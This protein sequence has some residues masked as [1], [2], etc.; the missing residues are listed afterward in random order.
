MVELDRVLSCYEATMKD[1]H[2][3]IAGGTG[4]L[5]TEITN[6]V[7]K[8]GGRVTIITRQTSKLARAGNESLQYVSWDAD[9]AAT[10][11]GT[12]A[13]INLS[14]AS[15]GSKRWS[16]K[17]KREILTSRVEAT[18][19]LVSAIA[20][21]SHPPVLVQASGV[22]YY[23]NTSVPSTESMP[24]GATFLSVVCKHWEDEAKKAE[25]FTRVVTLRIGI[26]LDPNE[27][28]LAKLKIPTMLFVGGPLGSGRQ[29]MPWVHRDDV[30]RAFLWAAVSNSAH[31]EY[32]LSAPNPVQMSTLARVLAKVLR[33][34]SYLPVPSFL[35]RI[36]LG[37]QADMVLHG[38]YI[39]QRRLEMDG[40]RFQFRDLLTALTNLFAKA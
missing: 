19:S 21:L 1:L 9:L 15:V 34:P 14:G 26:V 24:V 16:A 35:L 32:N 12:D 8:D 5:G 36:I 25:A 30:V 27:G 4:F 6:R 29:W 23:G 22:G 20:R 13:V 31:G 38:Q 3:V 33:R 17:R 28:A 40:F 10:L 18:R 7:I 11:E 2:I 37:Q 39:I